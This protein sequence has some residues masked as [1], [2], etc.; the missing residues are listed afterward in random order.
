MNTIR[1]IALGLFFGGVLGGTAPLSFG[2]DTPAAPSRKIIERTNIAGTD[3]E[4]RLM[5]VEYPPG[6]SSPSHI[7]P[8]VG[9]CYV[10]EG[11]AE[12]QYEG[13]EVKTFRT[14]DSY[15]DLAN[16]KHL[17]FRNTSPTDILKFTCTAKINKE[18]SFT[19]PI[20][21]ADTHP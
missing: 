8:V 20:D 18:L 14:G 17:L 2:A 15:Q 7:H 9:L 21:K 3:E 12:S 13:E 19:Q 16:R 4:L 10:I 1:N 5:L 6:Y 11:T